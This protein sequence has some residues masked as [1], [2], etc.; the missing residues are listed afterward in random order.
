M[1]RL[2]S[3]SGQFIWPR[4]FVACGHVAE[5]ENA[6]VNRDRCVRKL[7]PATGK[8][9]EQTSECVACH[10]PVLVLEECVNL[11]VH[12]NEVPRNRSGNRLLAHRLASQCGC[13][14]LL[15]S[16]MMRL[17]LA[18]P[19]AHFPGH[20]CRLNDSRCDSNNNNKIN[21]SGSHNIHHGRSI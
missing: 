18:V 16:W 21:C 15:R 20:N 6:R 19:G 7:W 11:N 13:A 2:L 4:S 5:P 8:L 12:V 14:V 9:A 17:A 3:A 1:G 10:V